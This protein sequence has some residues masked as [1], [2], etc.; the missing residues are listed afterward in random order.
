MAVHG[1]NG[2]ALETW[3]HKQSK[4][5]WLRDLLPQE[6]SNVRIMSYGYNAKFHNFTGHQDLRNISMKLLCELSDLRKNEEVRGYL[7][8]QRVQELHYLTYGLGTEQTNCI[9]VSQSGWNRC[10]EGMPYI[11][12][13]SCTYTSALLTGFRRYSFTAVKNKLPC[14][15]QR[16][17][18]YFSVRKPNDY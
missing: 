11:M 6:L 10:Q 7:V 1:L 8:L 13:Y 18:L 15:M 5:M 12:K 16:M 9:C 3:T 4:V 2:D 14:R 17:E